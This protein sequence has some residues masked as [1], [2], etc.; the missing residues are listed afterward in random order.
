MNEQGRQILQH[1]EAVAL[2][3]AQRRADPVLDKGVAEIKAFQHGRFAGTYA[4]LLG[5][6]RYAAAARF[7]L[8]ELYGPKDFS[9]RDHQFA[10]IVPGL[11][12]LFPSELVSTVAALADLHALSESLDTRMARA[13]SGGPLTLAA[14]AAAWRQVGEPAAR[15]RQ[16]LLMK[17][18]G[19]ALARYTRNPLLRHSLRLMRGPAQAAGVGVLQRFLEAGFDTFGHLKDPRHFLDLIAARERSL[20]AELFAGGST[21]PVPGFDAMG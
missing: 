1:L 21:G 6:P 3:R 18:V 16:I 13:A 17:E 20:A 10:R 15:E 2:E 14:Y 11:V 8:E 7:F 5:E 9:E 19:D 12:R 4:D